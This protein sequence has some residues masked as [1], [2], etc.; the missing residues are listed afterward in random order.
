MNRNS[1]ASPLA[2]ALLALAALPG[3]ALA[4]ADS[5][6]YLGGSLG[7]STFDVDVEGDNFDAD[8][9]AWKAFGG[10][11]FGLVPLVDLA[12]EASYVDLGEGSE[13]L[14]SIGAVDLDIKGMDVFGLVGLNF[15]PFGVFAKA[16]FMSWDSDVSVF[17]QQVLSDDGTDAAYGLGARFQIGSFQIR[18]EAEM[19]DIDAFPVDT[20]FNDIYLLSLG[21][22]YTF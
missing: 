17:G 4:G 1:L 19:F 5:G 7:S 21:F 16:G 2:I 10:Y 8:A 6:F 13:T 22:S 14:A 15:G 20:S 9:S 11:N 3:T 12:I 18:A